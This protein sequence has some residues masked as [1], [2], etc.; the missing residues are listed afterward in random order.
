MLTAL[1]TVSKT[2]T[3]GA[4]TPPGGDILPQTC[5]GTPGVTCPTTTRRIDSGDAFIR[6]NVVFRNGNIWY[7]QTIALP[8]GGLG[9][10][11]THTATQW[12][13][14]DTSGNFVDGGRVEDSTASAQV[15]WKPSTA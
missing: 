12:T 9:Q 13:R 3:G 4:W 2:R 5:V 15:D 11:N 8:A 6:S 14:I 10:A 1:S 7:P